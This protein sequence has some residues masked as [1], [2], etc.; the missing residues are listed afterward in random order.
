MVFISATLSFTEFIAKQRS[1]GSSKFKK[2]RYKKEILHQD[3][4]SGFWGLS[5]ITLSPQY[6]TTPPDFVRLLSLYTN[7]IK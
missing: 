3:D 2:L 4:H 7:I 5:I 1:S 6:H